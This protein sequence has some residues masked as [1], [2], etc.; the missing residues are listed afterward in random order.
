MP[1]P[2]HDLFV[3]RPHNG[4]HRVAARASISVFV[5]LLVLWLIG[6]TE[7]TIYASFGAFTALYGRNHAHLTR[8]QMQL[9]AAAGLCL[10]VVAGTTVGI[11]DQRFWLAG[12]IAPIVAILS[13]FLGDAIDM[14]PPG[15]LFFVFAFGATASSPHTPAHVG[16]AAAVSVATALFAVAVGSAGRLVRPTPYAA[17]TLRWRFEPKHLVYGAAV[18][19]AGI[20]PT[21]LGLAH[22]YWAAVA[23]IAPLTVR[24]RRAQVIRGVHRICGTLLGLIVAAPLLAWHPR[25]LAFVLTAAVLQALA[26]LFVGRNY[27]LALAFVTPL[28]LV[29]GSGAV[30]GDWVA[31]LGDRALE[32]TLGAAVGILFVFALE[33]RGDRVRA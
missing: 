22:P 9:A 27:G 18:L 32:T 7:W 1:A 29:M 11:C 15:P 26:E 23:A 6:H 31:A 2:I 33:L 16:I 10:S 20:V 14:H 17:L 4:A 30:R 5:P 8:A 24:G 21:A 12:L 19:T 3:V 13:A 28:A 25:G